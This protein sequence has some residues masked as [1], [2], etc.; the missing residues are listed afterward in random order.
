MP[1]M[2]AAIKYTA[3][4][5]ALVL[6][7]GS[8]AWA[9]NYGTQGGTNAG[10]QSATGESATGQSATGQSGMGQSSPG[11]V[12]SDTQQKIRQ[13]L[14]QHGFRD[15][16]VLP[17]AY[18]IR[19]QAPDGSRVAM[20]VTPDQVTEVVA[21]NIGPGMSGAGSQPSGTM[22]SSQNG[23]GFGNGPTVSQQQAQQELSRYGYTQLQN[24]T[25]MRGWVADAT[26]N[27]QN[28]RILLSDNGLVAT[29]PGR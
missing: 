21:G 14:E 6:S 25:P 20:L 10:S 13:A 23:N 9:Q 28:V 15:V 29:F 4:A 7:A 2:I 12:S 19:G 11:T 27:G 3:L 22:S 8:A 5:S 17:E 26:R 1:K 24:L 16:Q 18:I